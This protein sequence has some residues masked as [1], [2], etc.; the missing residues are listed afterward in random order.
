IRPIIYLGEE[1]PGGLFSPIFSQSLNLDSQF[2]MKFDLTKSIK[3]NFQSNRNGV[4]ANEDQRRRTKN[5]D[6]WEQIWT[7]GTAR[8]YHQTFNATYRV[9]FQY[10]APLKWISANAKYNA[11][12]DWIGANT[13]MQSFGNTIQNTREAQ[14]N[15][16]LD[17]SKLYKT[18][19]YIK[20]AYGGRGKSASKLKK[21][22]KKK[23]KKKA[24]KSVKKIEKLTAKGQSILEKS[25]AVADS[26]Q[27]ETS[28]P[29]DT[30]PDNIQ[31]AINKEEAKAKATADKFK[32]KE[33]KLSERLKKSRKKLPKA[34][35]AGV[36][37]LTA[38]KKVDLTYRRSEG[39]ALPGFR[40][41]TG[42]FDGQNLTAPGLGFLFGQ[43]ERF[44]ASGTNI[45]DYANENG[46]IVDT[47]GL[48]TQFSNTYQEHIN[49]KAI[50]EPIKRFKIN[51][52]ANRMESLNTT[53]YFR[54]T[55]NGGKPVRQN[56]AEQGTF[57]MSMLSINTAFKDQ[58]QIW[59]TFLDNRK[60]IAQRLAEQEMNTPVQ[61]D[62]NGYP[63]GFGESSQEVLIPSFLAAYTGKNASTQSLTKF[64]KIPMPNWKLS[65][66]GLRNLKFLKKSVKRISF[67]SGYTSVYTVGGFSRNLLYDEAKAFQYGLDDNIDFSGNFIPKYQIN[68]VNIS[69]QF[70]PLI[71]VDITLKNNMSLKT[72]FKKSRNL[73]LNIDN[74]QLLQE[75]LRSYVIGMSYR[76]NDV[77]IFKGPLSKSKIPRTLEAS[78]D[79][80]YNY[81]KSLVRNI[82]D[83]GQQVNSG[84]Q[85]MG[86]N[87]ELKYTINENLGCTFYVDRNSSEAFILSS[88]PTRETLVGFKIKYTFNQ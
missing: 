54:P 3:L 28:K 19:P 2:G 44:G 61:Y 26:T 82:Y 14:L 4:F 42:W 9:P 74:S 77:K 73:S 43:Q 55:E 62:A 85:V 27:V 29:E 70:N 33:K 78:F 65:Y 15:T 13:I 16:T 47:V 66:D 10:I 52:D 7:G 23:A 36:R 45:L 25:A 17:F 53:M 58:D 39:I 67:T 69:E 75:N 79:V 31:D 8:T 49:L 72:E 46:W 84:N 57:S 34:I 80:N 88:F 51:L 76:M 35:D 48:N 60:A 87:V 32:D 24:D 63:I 38:V 12:Y 40:P 59:Q 21:K 86:F 71:K 6:L 18:I 11:N 22:L 41:E 20:K 81:R 50:V 56:Q 68:Q 5:G 83:E 37:L 1:T 30:L 64:P